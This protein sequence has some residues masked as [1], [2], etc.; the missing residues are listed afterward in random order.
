MHAPPENEKRRPWQDGAIDKSE[1][2]RYSI[3]V[4]TQACLFI[5]L[6]IFLMV[7]ILAI[8]ARL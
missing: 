5:L 7:V 1:K 8:G 6:P 4:E 2:Q 3:S